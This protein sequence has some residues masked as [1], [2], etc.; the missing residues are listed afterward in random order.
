MLEVLLNITV[1]LI[2]DFNDSDRGFRVIVTVPS[3]LESRRV[4][5]ELSLNG[6]VVDGSLNLFVG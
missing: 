5:A 2:V 4:L 3:G 6:E 1:N